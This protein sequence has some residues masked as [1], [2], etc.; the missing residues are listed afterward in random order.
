M[1]IRLFFGF[2]L[3]ELLVVIAIIG[4]L[5]AL[6]LPA[7]QAAREAARRMQC[8]N[9][10][11]QIGLAIHNFHDSRNGIVPSGVFNQNR[12][13]SFGL[14]YP[15][16]EQP[17]L[18][19]IVSTDPNI[20]SSGGYR[21]GYVTSNWWWNNTLSEPQRNGFGSVTTFMCPSRRSGVQR[22][23][24]PRNNETDSSGDNSWDAAGPLGD[25][26]FVFGT[27]ADVHVGVAAWF[28]H[29][30]D[31]SQTDTT[32]A[33]SR[34]VSPF[35][36][37]IARETG[38]GS[39][40]RMIWEPR[41]DFARIADG[42]SNQF[43]VGEKHIPL[44]RVGKC[45]SGNNATITASADIT[46]N[47]SDCGYLQT[48]YR[49][50]VHAGRALVGYEHWGDASLGF[51]NGE[52]VYPICRASD[53]SETGNPTHTKFHQPIR[54][55]AFGSWHPGICPF[56]LG[57]GSVRSISVTTANAVLRAFAHCSDGAS[58]SLP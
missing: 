43:F 58:V 41:D 28:A 38:S 21:G 54:Y 36:K 51:P 9:N 31:Q 26:A 1:K 46:R 44:G 3:V 22:F 57:D 53:F 55:I 10:L 47:G 39:S 19:E 25:Y 4:V 5:I 24:N 11:K 42:L 37:A 16:I 33:T 14:L 32:D 13:S 17:A 18:Y 12:T 48:G 8:A 2:T 20:N 6:L 40:I 7:V 49:K 56:G 15:F 23:D 45:P 35:R 34:L 27:T 50:S 29:L 30:I 52:Y